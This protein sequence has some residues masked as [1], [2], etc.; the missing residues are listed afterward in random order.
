M[1]DWRLRGRE[2]KE[3]EKHLGDG[4]QVHDTSSCLPSGRNLQ[5]PDCAVWLSTY[6][7]TF[8]KWCCRNASWLKDVDDDGD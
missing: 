2:T 5:E 1:Q 6:G 8:L 3:R 7:W 4:P